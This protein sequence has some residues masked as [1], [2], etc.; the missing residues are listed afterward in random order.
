MR[1]VTTHL[2]FC[3]LH[4]AMWSG[5]NECKMQSAKC[6]VGRFQQLTSAVRD[7]PSAL[8]HDMKLSAQVVNIHKNYF[9]KGGIVVPALRGVSLD[10]PQGDFVAIMGASG[11]GK[12]TLL[13][14]LGC[15]DRPTSGSYILGGYNVAELS[16]DD[17]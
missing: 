2:A 9:L 12:S 11:S 4:F 14:L 15:L 16:D 7:P 17:L 13:N 5:L 3:I 8:R 1:P 10:F 6:K